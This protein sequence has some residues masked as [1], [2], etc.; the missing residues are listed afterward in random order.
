[1]KI[2]NNEFFQ[3]WV[4]RKTSKTANI[5]YS[6]YNSNDDKI[7]NSENFVNDIR[8]IVQHPFSI[9]LS[10]S[11]FVYTDRFPLTLV[12]RRKTVW[13]TATNAQHDT[14]FFLFLDKH[15]DSVNADE[16]LSWTDKE[17]KSINLKENETI[18][19]KISK[20]KILVR[21]NK[22]DFSTVP[23]LWILFDE[24]I[25]LTKTIYR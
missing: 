3:S 14:I 12:R 9:P 24:W 15:Q 20:L 4:K 1:M 17:T 16:Y 11:L 18:V 10:L 13:I 21:S 2:L 6:N 5:Y 23:F 22:F 25:L 7:C 8:F 19:V